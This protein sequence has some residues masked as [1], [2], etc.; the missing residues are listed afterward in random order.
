MWRQRRIVL[1]LVLLTASSCF[2]YEVVLKNGKTL[3]G[4]VV[5]ESP[6]MIVLQDSSG[7]KLHIKK[8]NIDSIKTQ[9]RNKKTDAIAAH[10]EKTEPVESDATVVEKPKTK[11]R[12]YTKKDLENMPELTILGDEESPD[13]VALRNEFEERSMQEKEAEAAWNEE[14]LRIDDQIKDAREAYENNK[15]FCDKVIPGVEDLREGAYVYRSAE[16][17]EEQRRIACME[18]EAAAKDLDKAQAEYEELLEDAR[19]K[20]I[21][22]GWVDPERIRN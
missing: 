4:E 2:A 21:P 14:A 9:E 20:G 10:P 1:F 22:P 3:D 15:S 6:E 11:P 18:A 5:S 12:V 13:D 7:V 19:K 16:Q 8:S 17:Y